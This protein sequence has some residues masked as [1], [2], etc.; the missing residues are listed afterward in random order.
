M[1]CLTVLS[2]AYPLAPVSPDSVGGS[3]QVLSALDR[4]LVSAG[5]RS[6]VVA[7]EGS[8]VAGELLPIPAMPPGAPVDDDAHMLRRAATWDAMVGALASNAVDVVH[9]HGFDF[10]Q[11]LPPPGPPLLATLHLPPSWY[12]DWAI[13]PANRPDIHVHCVSDSQ[14]RA[15]PPSPNLLPPIANGVPVAELDLP[16]RRR[17]RFALMLARVCPEKGLHLALDAAHAAGVPLLIAGEV[18]PYPTHQQYF[19]DEVQPRLDRLRRYIGPVGF[20]QKRR[21][22]SAA[23][24]LLAPSLVAETSSLVAMEAAACGTPVIAFRNGALPEVVEHGRTG[25]LVPDARAMA[26]A[27]REVD[28]IR[29]DE[30]RAVARARF[31]MERMVGDYFDRYHALVQGSV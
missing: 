4:A 24:C 14:M 20:S 26:D 21:L 19:R 8:N 16:R 30:C 23:R 22:L 18:F 25:Y 10:Y 5:H 15:T 1:R 2:T 31:S 13:A 12:P 27:I 17:C 11:Y 3:E 6:I 7:C 9:M 29:P 28:R